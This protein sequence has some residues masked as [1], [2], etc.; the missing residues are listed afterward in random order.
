MV[1]SGAVQGYLVH[2]VRT[3]TES[4]RGILM[5][6]ETI[7]DANRGAARASTAKGATVFVTES[8]EIAIAT[9]YLNGLAGMKPV[10]VECRPP[11]CR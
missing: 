6:V 1:R 3:G 8:R 7:D 9:A 4:G 5:L 10:A 2:P 11:D